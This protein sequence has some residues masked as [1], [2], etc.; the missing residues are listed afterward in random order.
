[1]AGKT[2][3]E[4]AHLCG[5]SFATALPTAPLGRWIGPVPSKHGEHLL[6]VVQREPARMPPFEEVEKQVR[7]DWLTQETRGFRTAAGTLLP[8]YQ[9]AIPADRR[10]QLGDSPALAPFLQGRR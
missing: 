4:L 10:A 3:L 8:R 9:V 7:A 5:E 2:E 6:R 1:V